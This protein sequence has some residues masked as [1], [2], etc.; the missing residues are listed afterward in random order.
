MH[1]TFD[2]RTQGKIPQ[3]AVLQRFI[4]SD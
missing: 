3:Q 2:L 4:C 1:V